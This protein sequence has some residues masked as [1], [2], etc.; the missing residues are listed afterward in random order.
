MSMAGEDSIKRMVLATGANS[1]IGAYWP[2][3]TY[4]GSDGELVGVR[5][6]L[7]SEFSPAA[8]WDAKKLGVKT[9]K[10][11]HVALMPLSASF[12]KM[13]VQ[14]GYGIFYQSTDARLVALIPDLASDELADSV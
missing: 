12:S 3:M 9:A 1:S 2:W 10:A 5:N 4:Q 7:R 11:S 8:E 14:G 6:R 13:A